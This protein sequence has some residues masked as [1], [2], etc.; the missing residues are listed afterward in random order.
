MIPTQPG[1]RQNQPPGYLPTDQ[2][3]GGFESEMTFFGEMAF[4]KIDFNDPV[5]HNAPPSTGV[6]PA[7]SQNGRFGIGVNF[8]RLESGCMEVSLLRTLILPSNV[9]VR[10][11]FRSHELGLSP[12]DK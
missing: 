2:S 6:A 3:R 1:D 7:K 12:C 8:K 5:A 4:D 11:F 10:Y 9:G